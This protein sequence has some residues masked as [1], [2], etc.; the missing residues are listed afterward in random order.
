VAAFVAPDAVELHSVAMNTA[1]L[2]QLATQSG[3]RPLSDPRE[4]AAGN[5]PGPAIQLW[6]WL[7]LAAL[8][9]LPLDVY[10]RRRA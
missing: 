4:L 10:L 1:V 8:V 2:E 6:P 5:G 3:G 7:L 9:A